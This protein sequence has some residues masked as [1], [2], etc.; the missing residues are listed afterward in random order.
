MNVFQQ[1][2]GD[3][4]ILYTLKGTNGQ[5]YVY[6]NKIEIAR[7]GLLA[8]AQQGLKGTKSIPISQIKSVQ[9]Y[10]NCKLKMR[11]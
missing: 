3:N 1:P 8:L 7:K 11:S 4:K 2:N 5:L 10:S 9:V 6:E